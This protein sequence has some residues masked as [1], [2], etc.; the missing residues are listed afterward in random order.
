MEYLHMERKIYVLIDENDVKCYFNL[1]QLTSD[2][3]KIPYFPAYRALLK[4]KSYYKD[5]YSIHINIIKYKT[6][7]GNNH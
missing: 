3:P 5:S 1:K 7:R 2:N 6:N 4:S